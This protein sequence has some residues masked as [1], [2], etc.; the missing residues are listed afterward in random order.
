[1][2]FREPLLLWLLLAVPLVLGFLASREK[3]RDAIA[4]RFVSERVRGLSNGV[5]ALR[6]ALLAAGL[7][8]AIVALAGP[9]FGS[10]VVPVEERQ[11][12]RILL[13]DVSDSM[14]AEDVGVSRWSAARAIA[15]RLIRAQPGRVALVI[16]ESS[17]QTVSPF[18]T[19]GEAVIALLD[20]I[21][22]GETNDPGS[23]LGAALTAA[24]K[25]AESEAGQ[26]TDIVLIS[27][28]EDQGSHLDVALARARTD[29]IPV[30]TVDLGTEQGAKIPIAGGPL[31][32]ES[33]QVVVTSSH[34]ETMRHIAAATGGETLVNPTTPSSLAALGAGPVAGGA[35]RVNWLH[36][37]IERFQWPL[38]G[39]IVFLMLG[40]IAHRGA[41]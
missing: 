13:M 23:D 7:G 29:G 15:R 1:V 36:V 25:L 3:R 8:L 11:S 10:T 26:K 17:P 33:G 22:P 19:D 34:P 4:R 37:P 32:D 16:F 2:S 31:Q 41:E 5:R 9:R 27:D 14:L 30:H 28:G 20:S 35:A 12:N 40:S 21:E 38:A 18:T 24:E 6:P 39:A